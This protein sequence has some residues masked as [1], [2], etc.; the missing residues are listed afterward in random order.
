MAHQHSY[1][2]QELLK[3]IRH[4][5]NKAFLN[6]TSNYGLVSGSFPHYKHIIMPPDQKAKLLA[7]HRASRAN[8]GIYVAVVLGVYL[9]LL[10]M[11]LCRYAKR[12]RPSPDAASLL[13]APPGI[14]TPTP[15][16][17]RGFF[18]CSRCNF[19]CHLRPD[20]IRTLF[21][22]LCCCR[23]APSSIEESIHEISDY[24]MTAVSTRIECKDRQRRKSKPVLV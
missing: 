12:H 6:E 23:K 17:R 8:A 18:S 1:E 2:L 3:L 20:R 10:T 16:R 21:K 11:L 24:P 14:A 15:E 19:T 4:S 5:S 13:T 22:R 9:V 7:M